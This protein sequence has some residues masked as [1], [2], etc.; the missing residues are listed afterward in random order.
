MNRKGQG[1]MLIISLLVAMVVGVAVALPVIVDTINSAS[2]ETLGIGEEFD[3]DL[4]VEATTS[5][6]NLVPDTDIMACP[7][8][9]M[10]NVNDY[11][12]DYPTGAFTIYDNRAFNNYTFTSNLDKNSSVSKGSVWIAY[13][14][15]AEVFNCSNVSQVYVE[16]TDYDIVGDV[17][18]QALS[19]G[20]IANN[21]L[22]CG[23]YTGSI[24]YQNAPCN[25][26]YEWYVAGEGTD[27]P[28]STI[29]NLIPIIFAIV[30]VS[31]VVGYIGLKG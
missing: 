30:L 20:D 29:T 2:A 26:Q 4:G 19:G 6:I 13:I 7:D 22:V 31:I 16:T 18:I 5:Q 25:I 17:F 9:L 8:T 10:S 3:A 14:D 23:N 15:S 1:Y 12:I 27:T 24:T 21:T 28:T 11:T